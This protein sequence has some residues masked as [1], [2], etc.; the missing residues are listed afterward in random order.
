MLNSTGLKQL[1]LGTAH[2][3]AQNPRIL[4]PLSSKPRPNSTVRLEHTEREYIHSSSARNFPGVVDPGA[5]LLEANLAVIPSRDY[6][7][8]GLTTM[9]SLSVPCQHIEPQLLTESHVAELPKGV[10][11]GDELF[12]YPSFQGAVIRCASSRA[13]FGAQRNFGTFGDQK[14]KV[15]F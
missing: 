4:D 2:I 6:I 7:D 15:W 1:A 3:Y 5:L 14:L 13:R 8:T 9:P 10:S 11:V 12:R